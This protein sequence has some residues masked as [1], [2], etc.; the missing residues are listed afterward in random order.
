MVYIMSFFGFKSNSF[1]ALVSGAI[2]S[3]FLSRKVVWNPAPGDKLR[4]A[5]DIVKNN[6]M[7]LKGHRELAAEPCV[8]ATL[9]RI[10]MWAPISSDR[11]IL[12]EAVRAGAALLA[13]TGGPG[14]LVVALP[15]TEPRLFPA[16]GVPI[17]LRDANG[18]VNLDP[19]GKPCSIIL[20]RL[21]EICKVRGDLAPASA[22]PLNP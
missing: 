13:V 18:G 1:G 10:T 7:D 14:A 4:W 20:V 16:P 6:E 12:D 5:L 17:G 15:S 9:G 22:L 8:V 11:Q 3:T 2:E 19:R 21:E